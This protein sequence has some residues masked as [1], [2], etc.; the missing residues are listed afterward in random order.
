MLHP[1]QFSLRDL[2]HLRKEELMKIRTPIILTTLAMAASS[3][4]FQEQSAAKAA[5]QQKVGELKEAVA[6]NQANLKKYQWLQTTEVSIK[7]KTR[8]EEQAQ[9]RYGPDGKVQKTPVGNTP[10]AEPQAPPR[11][12]K[13]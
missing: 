1:V 11:G 3:L 8:K 4:W 2:R 7:G 13:G 10:A 12:L 9:C 5:L 6:A